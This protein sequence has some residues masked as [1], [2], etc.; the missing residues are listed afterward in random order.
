[1]EIG[2]V[3]DFFAHPVVAGIE[4]TGPVQ[5]GDTLHFRGHTTDLVIAVDSIQIDH[6]SVTSARAGQSIGIKV[7]ERVRHGDHVYKVIA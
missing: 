7:P 6:Q 5:V 2:V 4:L 1:M 3:S